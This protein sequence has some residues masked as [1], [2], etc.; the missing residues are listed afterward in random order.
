MKMAR[1][2]SLALAVVFAIVGLVFLLIPRDVLVFF[3]HFSTYCGLPPSP[4][5]DA[6]FYLVLAAAYMYLVTLLASLIYRHPAEKWF[7]L[8]LAHA[9]LAS[10]A[11]SLLLFF[12]HQPYLI[13]LANCVV[14]GSIGIIALLYYLKLGRPQ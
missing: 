10:S 12:W 5:Q 8:L 4:V 3:N 13:Y 9:K 11:L 7:P 2:L 1:P 6:G 14:D